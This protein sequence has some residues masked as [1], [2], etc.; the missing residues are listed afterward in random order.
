MI[1]AVAFLGHTVEIGVLTVLQ[2]V[3]SLSP[4]ISLERTTRRSSF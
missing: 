1:A 4:A 2:L 3:L